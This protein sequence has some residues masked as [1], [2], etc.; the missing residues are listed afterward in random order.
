MAGSS[1]RIAVP[2]AVTMGE[3]AGIGPEIT[4]KAWQTRREAGVQPFV[5]YGDPDVLS[6]AAR[7]LDCAFQSQR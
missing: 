3:P 5:V 1:P 6:S 2:L 4:V 7:A